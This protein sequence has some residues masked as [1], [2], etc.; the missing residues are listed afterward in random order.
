MGLTKQAKERAEAAKKLHSDVYKEKGTDNVNT[1][2]VNVEPTGEPVNEPVVEPQNVETV[3]KPAISQQTVTQPVQPVQTVLE[4]TVTPPVITV[5]PSVTPTTV[6]VIDDKKFE[7]KYKVLQ[8]KYNADIA[9]SSKQIDELTNTVTQLT[10]TIADIQKKLESNVNVNNANVNT[11]QVPSAS[12][13]SQISMDPYAYLPKETVDEWGP[14]WMNVTAKLAYEIANKMIEDKMKNAST[15]NNDINVN[16]LNSL[17]NTVQL[18]S[19]Q[20]FENRLLTLVPDWEDL[21]INDDGFKEWLSEPDGL[22][23]A[24]RYDNAMNAMSRLDADTV[25]RYCDAYKED[26]QRLAQTKSQNVQPVVNTP[27]TQPVTQSLQS[28]QSQVQ[29]QVITNAS[30]VNDI[31]PNATVRVSPNISAGKQ[32][33]S[34][35]DVTPPPQKKK[36]TI[37]MLRDAGIKLSKHEID[38]DKFNE[39]RQGYL[40]SMKEE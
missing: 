35:S 2:N 31:L 24:T 22:S 13:K 27:V 11:T 33:G 32:R 36:I 37:E 21:N 23:N 17:E 28:P 29:S 15:S 8:G 6:P 38:L 39:I 12:A 19:Q 26:K 9:K 25:A 7:H 30:P 5:T 3:A 1:D 16:K 4:Q 14:D 18:T 40:D 34:A 10:N 20:V